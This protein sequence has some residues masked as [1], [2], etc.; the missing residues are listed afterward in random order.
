MDGG[1]QEELGA[2]RLAHPQDIHSGLLNCRL[3]RSS[4]ENGR[5]RVLLL[6]LDTLVSFTK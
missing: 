2:T 5:I 1:D 6:T 3:R 4:V